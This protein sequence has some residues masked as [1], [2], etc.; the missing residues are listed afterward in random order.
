MLLFSQGGGVFTK[1]T[2]GHVSKSCGNSTCGCLDKG[3]VWTRGVRTKEEPTSLNMH[4][5]KGIGTT[6]MVRT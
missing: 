6:Q 2:V 4:A 5:P 3:I 1:G